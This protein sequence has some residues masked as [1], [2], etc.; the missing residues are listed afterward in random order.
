MTD[1]QRR[2]QLAANLTVVRD[3]VTAACAAAGRAAGEVTVV[4]VTKTW[5][6]DDVRRLA[7]LGLLDIGENRD[8]EAR[9]KAAACADL[10]LRWHFVGRLQRNKAA[11]VATYAHVV[12]SV[13]RLPLVAALS[14]GAVAAGREVT[15]LLQVSLDDTASRERGGADPAD[16]PALAEAIA[17]AAS[18]RLGGVM[19]VAPRGADPDDAFAR[20]ARVAREVARIHPEATMVSAG[21]SRDLEAAVRH[22]ATHVRV[23]TALLGHRAPP[24]G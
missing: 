5:P 6:A 13:D 4:A 16:V 17:A 2:G 19:A 9:Q 18:L 21:M 8:Q 22:G 3:R 11:S 20:L 12:H 23:G 15:A 14:R 10:P 24:V 7:G 1:E